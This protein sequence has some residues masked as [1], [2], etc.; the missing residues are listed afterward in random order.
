MS[1]RTIVSRVLQSCAIVAFCVSLGTAVHQAVAA[2]YHQAPKRHALRLRAPHYV[3]APDPFVED[4]VAYIEQRNAVPSPGPSVLALPGTVPGLPGGLQILGV[5]QKNG[6]SDL[7]VSGAAGTTQTLRVGD[8]IDATRTIAAISLDAV[9]LSDGTI[10]PILPQGAYGSPAVP[11]GSPYLV[12][13]L[14]PNPYGQTVTP[15]LPPYAAPQTTTPTPYMIP[16]NS[17]NPTPPPLPPY[18]NQATPKPPYATP[19]GH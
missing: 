19:G 4:P 17:L 9:R 11:A 3:A 12:P 13:A 2:Q 8:H 16:V 15:P 10:L 5:F 14:T 18:G 7:L 6:E 1:G